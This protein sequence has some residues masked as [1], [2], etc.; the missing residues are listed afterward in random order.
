[1]RENGSQIVRAK[2][3]LTLD[4]VGPAAKDKHL[5]Q[6]HRLKIDV[7]LRAIIEC[8]TSPTAMQLK[9]KPFLCLQPNMQTVTIYSC[10][11]HFYTAFYND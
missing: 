7:S 6:T 5:V 4:T 2:E 11:I 9:R 8:Y 3:N 1:M 10:Y